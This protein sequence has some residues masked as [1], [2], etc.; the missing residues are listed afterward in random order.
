MDNQDALPQYL[1]KLQSKEAVEKDVLHSTPLNQPPISPSVSKS[2]VLEKLQ[3]ETKTEILSKESLESSSDWSVLDP[4]DN[5]SDVFSDKETLTAVLTS[6][7]A[8]KRGQKEKKEAFCLKRHPPAV[9]KFTLISA[10]FQCKYKGIE[11]F[12]GRFIL[13]VYKTRNFLRVDYLS[14][15]EH[16]DNAE[17]VKGGKRRPMT[18][19]TLRSTPHSSFTLVSSLS[20]SP[21]CSIKET[22][23]RCHCSRMIYLHHSHQSQSNSLAYGERMHRDAILA[24]LIAARSTCARKLGYVIALRWMNQ[25]FKGL[26]TVG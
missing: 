3:E 1:K 7:F 15:A 19:P 4:N 25:K 22:G 11:E 9:L 21:E 26:I 17:T 13:Q 23:S 2:G 12:R 10:A 6:F 14:A 20:P 8:N 16:P 24:D 18:W 5:L